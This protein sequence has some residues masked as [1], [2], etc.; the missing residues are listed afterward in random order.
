[1]LAEQRV[2]ICFKKKQVHPLKDKSDLTDDVAKFVHN[3]L[4]RLTVRTN[5]LPQ[6]NVT[7]EVDAEIEAEKIYFQQ[8][9]ISYGRKARRLFH[10]VIL[11]SKAARKNLVLKAD[12]SIPLYEYDVKSCMPVILLGLAHDPAEKAKL[13]TLLDGDIYTTIAKER[14]VTKD[15]DDIKL[16]FMYFLNGSI[17]NYVHKYFHAHLPKLTE[18]VMKSKKAENGMAWFGQRVESEIMVQEIPRQLLNP[19]QSNPVQSNNVPNQSNL[20]L[21]CGGNPDDVLYIPM[22]DGWLGIERDEQK[23]AATVRDEFLRRL[24]YRITITKTELATGRETVLPAA[25]PQAQRT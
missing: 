25:A 6:A 1:V 2:K 7:D 18:L 22:H 14:G 9:N 16:D 17:P 12:P 13:K 11:M 4:K 23:I 3:N 24:D 19:V 5:L 10:N 15:R 20:S 8:W 21:T